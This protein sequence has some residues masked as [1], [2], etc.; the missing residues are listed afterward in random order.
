VHKHVEEQ[1]E[2]YLQE[3]KLQVK[4]S[5]TCIILDQKNIIMMDMHEIKCF[6]QADI[7]VA[8]ASCNH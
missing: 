8:S 1:K 7:A 5:T 4:I 2:G 3:R 6:T